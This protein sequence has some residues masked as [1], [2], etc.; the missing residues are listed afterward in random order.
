MQWKKLICLLL[1]LILTALC[2]AGCRGKKEEPVEE[3]PA[4]VEPAETEEPEE[5]AETA[6]TEPE[7]EPE[8]EPEEEAQVEMPQIEVVDELTDVPQAIDSG[9]E[10][11]I[12]VPEGSEVGGD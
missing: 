6:E 12:M 10:M 4:Q 2:F 9:E 11:V 5:T 3:T 1:A 7:P 8:E